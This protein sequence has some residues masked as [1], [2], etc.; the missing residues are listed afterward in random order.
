MKLDIQETGCVVH[1]ILLSCSFLFFFI[2]V[3]LFTFKTPNP[4]KVSI[5]KRMICDNSTSTI[6]IITSSTCSC[7]KQIPFNTVYFGVFAVFIF[8]HR[9]Y[10]KIDI[11]NAFCGEELLNTKN[12]V[13]TMKVGYA[14]YYTNKATSRHKVSKFKRLGIKP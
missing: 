10:P 5:T 13:L 12:S 1:K 2:F 8:I 7:K 14:A 4:S 9:C 11:K 3:Y 6:G